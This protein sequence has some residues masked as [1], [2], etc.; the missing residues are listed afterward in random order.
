MIRISVVGKVLIAGK[1]FASSNPQMVIT[2]VHAKAWRIQASGLRFA[3]TAAIS[4]SRTS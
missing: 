2:A 3:P 4:C 1:G